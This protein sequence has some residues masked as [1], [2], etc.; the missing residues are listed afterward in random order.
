M[1]PNPLARET[2]EYPFA[3]QHDGLAGMKLFDACMRELTSGP[4]ALTEDEAATLINLS[5]PQ[6]H[7][8]LVEG[9]QL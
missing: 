8:V 4:K 7:E 5:W 2:S 3:V 6:L 1:L 9:G